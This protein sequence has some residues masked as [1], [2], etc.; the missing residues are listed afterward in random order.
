M[1]VICGLAE[2]LNPQLT[3]KNGSA[4]HKSAKCNIC[5]RSAK[6]A[7]Y[8]RRKFEDL[9]FADRPQMKFA[10]GGMIPIFW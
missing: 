1:Y 9:R 6:L 10:I 5:G 4:N 3:T 8:L 7:N 2:V